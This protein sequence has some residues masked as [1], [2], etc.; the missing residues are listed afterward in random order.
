MV[1][2]PP[3]KVKANKKTNDAQSG[4]VKVLRNHAEGEII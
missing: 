2:V 1:N 3:E 4:L